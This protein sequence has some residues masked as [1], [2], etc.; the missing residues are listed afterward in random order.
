MDTMASSDAVDESIISVT[1][2]DGSIVKYTMRGLTVDEIQ[3]WAQF[4]ASVFAYKSNPPPASY[5]ERH[6]HNDPMRNA[7][8][9][10][11]MMY[12]KRI[13]SSCRIFVRSI[14]PGGIF[15]GGIG[16][17]CTDQQHRKR[18]LLKLLLQNAIQ[19]MN[20][21]NMKISLLH[22]AQE[23][24]PVYQKGGG[25]QSVSSQ[26]SVVTL[27]RSNLQEAEIPYTTR[28][29]KFPQD[30]PRLQEIHQEYSEQRFVG[31]IIRSRDYW[32]EYICK[33]LNGSLWTLVKND[34][35]VAW[36][37]LRLKGQTFQMQD[38]G[39]HVKS[40]SVSDALA[41]LLQVALQDVL[42]DEEQI[43][44]FLPTAVLDDMPQQ[45]CSFLDWSTVVIENDDGWMYKT[46]Q[47]DEVSMVEA[48]TTRNHL[49]WPAD[50]F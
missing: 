25:Y 2:E 22:A 47:Q 30:T 46:L 4:C 35:I 16:E 3:P 32:N 43:H 24:R 36:T 29:A 48:T 40:I 34:V 38:F 45:N 27:I 1:L 15:A 49:I 5:F 19:I 23:F 12:E 26:W 17:V 28:L 10:R 13:V 44:L 41:V 9:I 8:F 39:C 11:V 6:F 37:S 33:E 50:S 21:R 31:C 42:V 18:G 20:A 7:S 14:S